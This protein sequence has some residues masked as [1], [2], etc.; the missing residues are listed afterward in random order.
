[1]KDTGR[2]NCNIPVTNEVQV[3]KSDMEF[4]SNDKII[5]KNQNFIYAHFLP[6]VNITN[7]FISKIVIIDLFV[8]ARSESIV[9]TVRT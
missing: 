1:M 8:S 3:K 4:Q 6:M 7:L 9:I 2:C 5:L